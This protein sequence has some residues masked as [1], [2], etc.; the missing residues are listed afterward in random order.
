LNYTIKLLID[1]GFID[2]IQQNIEN[3]KVGLRCT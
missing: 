3:L 2:K 1:I